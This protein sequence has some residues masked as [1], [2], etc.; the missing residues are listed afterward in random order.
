MTEWCFFAL[1]NAN[2]CDGIGLNFVTEIREEVLRVYGSPL[3]ELR[4]YTPR[5]KT[6]LYYIDCLFRE[7]RGGALVTGALR[8]MPKNPLS[9]F[10]AYMEKGEDGMYNVS[11]P[12]STNIIRVLFKMLPTTPYDFRGDAKMANN[13]TSMC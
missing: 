11:L 7:E 12:N 2:V 10:F 1:H 6:I 3:N 8:F 9:A 5:L 4:H 13:D